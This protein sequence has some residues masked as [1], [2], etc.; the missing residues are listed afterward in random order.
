MG[1]DLLARSSSFGRLG[2]VSV[3]VPW[4]D[5]D[6]EAI[7]E[8]VSAR[9]PLGGTCWNGVGD[10]PIN[11]PWVEGFCVLT[12]N[13]TV[14]FVILLVGGIE[15]RMVGRGSEGFGKRVLLSMA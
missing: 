14:I 12:G 9:R 4:P 11:D 13:L 2:C 8:N 3:T 6:D 7:F 1:D 15:A 5:P 10:E